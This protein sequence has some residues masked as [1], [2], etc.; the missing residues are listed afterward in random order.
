MNERDYSGSLERGITKPIAK[1]K[2]N[3]YGT[4]VNLLECCF[5]CIAIDRA[6]DMASYG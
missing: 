6:A 2:N 5:Q 4:T 3:F 1:L